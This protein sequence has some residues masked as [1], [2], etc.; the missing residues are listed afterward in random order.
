MKAKIQPAT[1]PRELRGVLD[2]ARA[3][4]GKP[5][6]NEGGLALNQGPWREDIIQMLNEALATVL[7]GVLR[8]KRR[9]L[10]ATGLFAAGVAIEAYSQ[11]IARL[12]AKDSS[13]RWTAEGVLSQGQ[14]HT[15]ELSDW[16]TA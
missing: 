10:A 4:A 1:P 5:L 9:H 2:E 14:E 13:S 11:M 12:G 15:L 16:L 3:E 6:L 8:A 7:V